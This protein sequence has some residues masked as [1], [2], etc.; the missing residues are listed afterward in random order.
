MHVVWGK[1]II[2]WKHSSMMQVIFA[3]FEIYDMI[4]TLIF[5]FLWPSLRKTT[6]GKL[7]STEKEPFLMAWYK[8]KGTKTPGDVKFKNN[9]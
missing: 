4:C 8:H 9:T 5:L 1:L 6:I 7:E 3:A 2:F